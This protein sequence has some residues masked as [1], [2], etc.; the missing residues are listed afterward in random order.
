MNHD[1]GLN[2]IAQ[3]SYVNIYSGIEITDG[4]QMVFSSSSGQQS[5]F[6]A[7]R[8]TRIS[9]TSYV[10]RSAGRVRLTIS[11][12]S[13]VGANYISFYNSGFEGKLIYAR[14][15]DW[16][17]INN[18]CV[19]IDFT[20][21]YFQTFMF[22]VTYDKCQI[23]REHLS[24]SDW[25]LAV[26]NPYRNDIRELTTD[27]PF[28]FGAED[29]KYV[30]S[31]N[32]TYLDGDVNWDGKLVNVLEL[33]SVAYIAED[34]PFLS[35]IQELFTRLTESTMTASGWGGKTTDWNRT[36]VPAAV[37]RD[38]VPH[39]SGIYFI[40]ASDTLT[41]SEAATL[42]NGA[43]AY[44]DSFS[45]GMSTLSAFTKALTLAGLSSSIISLNCVF[46]WQLY[47]YAHDEP[48][49]SITPTA[50]TGTNPKLYRSPF[51]YYKVLSG[52][53]SVKE[54]MYERF[55]EPSQGC[56]FTL[57]TK[58]FQ[59]VET[60]LVPNNYDFA[61]PNI[62]ERMEAPQAAQPPYMIDAYLTYLSG[63]YQ[64]GLMNKNVSGAATASQ[65]WGGSAQGALQAVGTSN[66][67]KI[68]GA[69]VNAAGAQALQGVGTALG[70]D[71][72]AVYQKA[73]GTAS[74]GM[75]NGS[76]LGMVPIDLYSGQK[77]AY[78]NDQYVPGCNPGWAYKLNK[79]YMTA[80]RGLP[81][82]LR[83]DNAMLVDD[84]FDMYGYNS[85]R[86][87]RPR[88]TAYMGRSSE[89]TPHFINGATYCQT[90]DCRVIAPLRAASV[91][92]QNLFNGGCSFKKGD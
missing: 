24:D 43:T 5:Y 17:Y 53:G 49:S 64:Q 37:T 14:I 52:D 18:Q 44:G 4:H 12:S 60:A 90:A 47:A 67:A 33:G 2:K 30:E 88:V 46:T 79:G 55:Y 82:V 13:I 29:Y 45:A 87:G 3:N 34:Y 8:I 1:D 25:S 86:I 31:S 35:A 50:T 72:S 81:M 80:F 76:L 11:T 7:K 66:E 38:R 27:E 26:A 58:L 77:S 74:I 9:N 85:G 16:T 63:V 21:D 54:Y 57:T 83:D 89:S 20:V 40:A 73:G 36:M 78:I 19:E 91:E 23:V 68:N 48:Y 62:P 39:C 28:N 15:T 61:G 92:I 71:L 6:A 32:M 10:Q 70:S 42:N 56:K 41:S 51:S 59:G 22:D 75:G 84:Y 65:I 69:G